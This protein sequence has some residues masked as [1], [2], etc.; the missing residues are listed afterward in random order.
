MIKDT[1]ECI[2]NST[3]RIKI[4]EGWLVRSVRE[5]H[6]ALIIVPD[7]DHKWDVEIDED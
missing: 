2:Y 1:W 4:P 7:Q 6:L 3:D 5:N